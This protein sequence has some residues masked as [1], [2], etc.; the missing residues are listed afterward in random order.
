MS[1]QDWTYI[2]A[3]IT[4]GVTTIISTVFAGWATL[5]QNPQIHALVNRNFSEQKTEIATL[6]E[7]VELLQTAALDKEEAREA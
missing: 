2:I 1:A 5:R 3:A 6:R 7:K 4:V